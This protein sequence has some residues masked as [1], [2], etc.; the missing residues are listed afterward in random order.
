MGGAFGGG[1]AGF[2]T[3]EVAARWGCTW[4]SES[5][6]E[7]YKEGLGDRLMGKGGCRVERE[8]ASGEMTKFWLEG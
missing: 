6:M 3:S 7:R 2:Q 8:A 4:D 5:R 1:D